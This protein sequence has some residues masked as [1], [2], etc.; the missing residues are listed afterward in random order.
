MP[1]GQYYPVVDGRISLAYALALGFFLEPGFGVSS[2]NY[3][4]VSCG[5]FFQ[6]TLLQWVQW[7]SGGVSHS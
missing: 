7:S 1:D 4:L 3:F 5:V 2:Q 6:L